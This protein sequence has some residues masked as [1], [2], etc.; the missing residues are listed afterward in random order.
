MLSQAMMVFINI[1]HLYTVFRNNQLLWWRQKKRKTI[2]E[3]KTGQPLLEC[4]AHLIPTLSMLNNARLCKKKTENETLS[5][6]PGSVTEPA[7]STVT[8]LTEGVEIR[9]KGICRSVLWNL[10]C[11]VAR[12]YSGAAM[13]LIAE[14]T[15]WSVLWQT[16]VPVEKNTSLTK[17]ISLTKVRLYWP[18]KERLPL[19]ETV[20]NKSKRKTQVA[21]PRKIK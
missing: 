17:E 14:G 19:G 20:P 8:A 11:I 21:R 13:T 12:W 2:T 16:E 10:G 15:T 6:S 1:L 7:V 3:I 18:R 4:T 5:S 9:G